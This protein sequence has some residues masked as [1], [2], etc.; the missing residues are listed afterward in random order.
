MEQIQNPKRCAG[1]AIAGGILLLISEIFVLIGNLIYFIPAG[2]PAN[3]Y[4][5]SI[6]VCLLYIFFAITLLTR[7]RNFLQLIPV[8]LIVIY[9]LYTKLTY[10]LGQGAQNLNEYLYD[11]GFSGIEI[12]LYNLAYIV[13]ALPM[14]FMVVVII[15]AATNR[16]HTLCA[17][18][19]I[20][21]LIGFALNTLVLISFIGRIL[22]PNLLFSQLNLLSALGIL[23]AGIGIG[24]PAVEYNL[25]GAGGSL[26]GVYGHVSMGAHIAGLFLTFGIYLLVWIYRSTAAL[27]RDEPEPPRSP[28]AK[29][30][31]CMFVPFYYLYWIY[32]SAQRLD[33]LSEKYG[34]TSNMATICLI[35]AIFI[36]FVPPIL[37]QDKLNNIIEYENG[38]SAPQYNR[39]TNIDAADELKKYKELLDAGAITQEEYE[40]KKAQLLNM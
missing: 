20:F 14:I 31:L 30:A 16:K 9:E 37:I 32:K 6:I 21:A 34:E 8:A 2:A 26:K 4:L 25:N 17:L 38:K 33:R 19:G 40:A 1:Q 27:N 11:Y 15:L 5:P 24:K 7:K 18:P 29:H 10:F 36:G 35:L 39:P 12:E 22:I 28:G 13:S 3:T 23:F